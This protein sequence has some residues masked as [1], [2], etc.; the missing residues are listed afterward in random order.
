M[1]TRIKK[2]RK[3]L[4]LTQAE[5]AKRIS[6]TTSRVSQWEKDGNLSNTSIKK[7]CSIFG[8]NVEWLLDGKGETFAEPVRLHKGDRL[9]LAREKAGLSQ[10]YFAELAGLHL[11]TVYLWEKNGVFPD[12]YISVF[13]DILHIN[14]E[15]LVDG[16]G[17]ME[18][19][20]ADVVFKRIY[21]M[22]T[23]LGKEEKR[24]ILLTLQLV[25]NCVAQS[26]RAESQRGAGVENAGGNVVVAHTVGDVHQSAE[27]KK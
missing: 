14:P 18:R 12:Q 5:F 26:E 11:N 23:G 15:W 10:S 24:A 9:K 16:R 2:L 21:D 17:E 4:G 19:D 13:S 27:V 3:L 20:D 25:T 7:I 6:V 1:N 8:V 22:T